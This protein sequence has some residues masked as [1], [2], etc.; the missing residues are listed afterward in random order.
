M[1][2]RITFLTIVICLIIF[3]SI[4]P[5]IALSENL[6]TLV[7][8]YYNS[9]TQLTILNRD[10]MSLEKSVA[11][12]NDGRK[13][14]EIKIKNIEGNI[15][16]LDSEV[17]TL[18]TTIQENKN[19]KNEIDRNIHIIDVL[20]DR[21]STFLFGTFIGLIIGLWTISLPLVLLWGK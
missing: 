4:V 10:K 3:L 11:D 15:D 5:S 1:F 8:Q 2:K 9:T 6:Q 19:K 21:E 7:D 13:K 12:L 17:A 14:L 16:I 20:N 18:D